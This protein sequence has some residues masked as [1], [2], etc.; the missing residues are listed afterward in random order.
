[1]EI[2][3]NLNA[4]LFLSTIS[5]LSSKIGITVQHGPKITPSAG[6]LTRL[7]STVWTPFLSVSERQDK[8]P[9]I[10]EMRTTH[11]HNRR[12]HGPHKQEVDMM[13]YIYSCLFAEK[14]FNCMIVFSSKIQTQGK[15]TKRRR[16]FDPTADKYNFSDCS[17]LSELFE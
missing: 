12:K 4:S 17:S 15:E 10:I 5:Q 1:M 2:L 14:Y 6:S 11:R 8:L 9:V 13:G 7:S 16:C 3:R